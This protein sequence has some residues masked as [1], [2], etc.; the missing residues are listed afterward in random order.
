METIIRKYTEADK[1][2]LLELIQLNT[3]QYFSLSE[4]EDFVLY[5]D[6]YREEY[7]VIEY[8]NK[9]CGCGGIN[10]EPNLQMA[11]LSWDMVHPNYHGLGIGTLLTQFRINHIKQMQDIKT[12]IVRTSQVAYKFYEKFGF[13][14]IDYQKNY[15][16]PGFD[17]Y[18][19]ELILK[20]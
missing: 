7:F 8:E 14:K 11:K 5:L 20:K 13:T 10:V 15:W 16:A 4:T 9:I 19:M 2:L 12:I 1:P 3:P 6:K 17:L 18:T